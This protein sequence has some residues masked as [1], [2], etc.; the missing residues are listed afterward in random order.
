[1]LAVFSLILSSCARNFNTVDFK[2]S[3]NAHQ[4][5]RSG[6]A[7]IDTPPEQLV[8]DLS[9]ALRQQ[10]AI[11]LQREKIDY[12]LEED[13][14]AEACWQANSE[15]F[16]KEFHAYETNS[17]S[18]YQAIDRVAPYQN[19]GISQN[20]RIFNEISTGE[21]QSWLLMVQ[22]PAER[23][24]TTVYRPTSSRFF[25]FDGKNAPI[26]AY[27]SSAVAEDIEI[28][29]TTRLYLWA[30]QNEDGKTNLY[31]EGRPFSGQVEAASG[32][33]IGWKWWK[34]SNGYRESEVVRS[35]VLLIQDYDRDHFSP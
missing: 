15:I 19:R 11:V 9:A 29:I 4:S 31:L 16:Q 10:G 1:M 22:L 7:E 12:I 27:S 14:N 2:Y 32:N 13:K 25:I 33:S 18:L 23:F 8:V 20:C 28:D 3:S 6:M 5:F 24:N 21:K 30:W 17:F 34:V 26:N 35:Y